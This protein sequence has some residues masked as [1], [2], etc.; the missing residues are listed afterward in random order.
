[1]LTQEFA[2]VIP[3]LRVQASPGNNETQEIIAPDGLW[4]GPFSDEIVIHGCIF[5][6]CQPGERSIIIQ[7]PEDTE[8]DFDVQCDASMNREEFLCSSCRDGYS[9]MLG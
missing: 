5:R 9:A 7:S 3:D 8:I 1:M 2:H 6:Y 4:I